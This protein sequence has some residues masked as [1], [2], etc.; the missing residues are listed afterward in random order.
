MLKELGIKFGVVPVFRVVP[1]SKAE[2]E[3][4]SKLWI[5]AYKQAWS[6]S[7]NMDGSPIVLNRDDGGRECPSAVEECTRA[8]PDLWDKC[9]PFQVKSRGLSDITCNIAALTMDAMP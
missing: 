4:I 5:L 8:V 6:F 7:S 9:I 1:G 3:Q 2:L